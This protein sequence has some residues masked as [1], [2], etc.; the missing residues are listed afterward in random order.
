MVTSDLQAR[1]EGDQY[2]IDSRHADAADKF[3]QREL[4]AAQ[5]AWLFVE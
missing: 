5:G 3:E 1:V 2:R 4:R